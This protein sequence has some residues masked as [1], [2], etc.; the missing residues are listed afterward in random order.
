[1][2]LV[3]GATG[4]S[5]RKLI[6]KLAT[7]GLP[8]RAL[9]RNPAR[10]TRPLPAGVGLAVGNYDQPATIEPALAG[11]DR[12]YLVSSEHPA[13]VQRERAIIEAAQRHG[14][15]HVVKLSC[16]HAHPGSHLPVCRH[17]GE[18]EAHL[19]RLRV[20]FTSLRPHYLM[21]NL[22]MYER[23]VREHGML[24]APAGHASIGMLDAEDLADVALVTLTRPGHADKRYDLSG[25]EAVSF[26]MLAR[27]LGRVLG[28]PVRYVD[29]PAEQAVAEMQALGIS[30]WH[31]RSIVRDYR[32]YGEGLS[33]VTTT[34]RDLLGRPARSIETFVRALFNAR[35]D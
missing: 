31:A 7:A 23:A 22:R 2:I 10:L 29:L 30:A 12:L 6:D 5:G 1:M 4:H 20:P 26:D 21:Q 32:A 28:R 27:V 8:V 33:C 16:R 3:T 35:D 13:Q 34:V 19:A 14:V 24:R 25:P 15:T 9:V 11:V 17:H 18:I